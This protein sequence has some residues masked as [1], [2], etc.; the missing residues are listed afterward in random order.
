MQYYLLNRQQDDDDD[1]FGGGGFE[2]ELAQMDTDRETVIGEG[3]ETHQT[4]VKWVF[5]WR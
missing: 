5:Y 4:F 3:P 2:M 1:D